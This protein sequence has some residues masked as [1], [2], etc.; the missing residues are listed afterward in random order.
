MV[1]SKLLQQV[2]G[3]MDLFVGLHARKVVCAFDLVDWEESGTTFKQNIKMV[4]M[5]AE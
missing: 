3:Q 5:P 2:F 4:N 1:A